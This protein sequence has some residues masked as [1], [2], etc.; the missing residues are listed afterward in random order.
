MKAVSMFMNALNG[1]IQLA[2]LPE[3]M[4]V[5]SLANNKLTGGLDL[6]SLL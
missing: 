1:T 6:D 4:E 5:V 3:K 2:D